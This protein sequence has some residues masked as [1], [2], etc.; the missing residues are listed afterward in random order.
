MQTFLPYESF[1]VSAQCLD[2]K[3]CWKQVVE[4]KQL[5]N[6]LL[7]RP[8]LDRKTGQMRVKTGWVRHSACRQWVGYENALKHYYNI[9]LEHCLKVH[10]IRTV[11]VFEVIDGEIIMPPWMG[12]E[13]FHAS[14]RSNLLRKKFEF[15][16]H[17]RWKEPAN[18][19]YVWPSKL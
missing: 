4:A 8:T 5:L 6:A 17:Y 12:M 14:H 1:K 15:Y 16:S 18:L 2:K 3:R 10:K 19:P 7:R 11:Q 9:F 13:K